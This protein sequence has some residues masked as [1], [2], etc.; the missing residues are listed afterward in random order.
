LLLFAK[1]IYID[2]IADSY[3]DYSEVSLPRRQGGQG[4]HCVGASYQ[5]KH[6]TSSHHQK[7]YHRIARTAGAVEIRTIRLIR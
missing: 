7:K 3:R 5:L 2:K 1:T 6:T 4:G